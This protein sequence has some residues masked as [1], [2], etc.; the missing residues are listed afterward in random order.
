MKRITQ[1]AVFFFLIGLLSLVVGSLLLTYAAGDAGY[2]NAGWWLVG[3]GGACIFLFICS[4]IYMY[5][6]IGEARRV[7][8]EELRNGTYYEE[9][10]IQQSGRLSYLPVI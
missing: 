2:L 6:W 4:V 1:F 7:H 3:I 10:P 8:N 9:P 5:G